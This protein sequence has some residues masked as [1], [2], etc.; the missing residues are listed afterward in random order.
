MKLNIVLCLSTFLT[1]VSAGKEDSLIGSWFD[2]APDDD[3]VVDVARFV[4]SKF[5]YVMIEV[6]RAQIQDLVRKC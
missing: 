4:A 1:L 5:G 6:E 3:D 2:Q